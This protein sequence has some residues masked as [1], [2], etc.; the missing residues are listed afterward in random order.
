VRTSETL[1]PAG[2]NNLY[3][4]ATVS[5]VIRQVNKNS[6]EN[7]NYDKYIRITTTKEEDARAI[8][9]AYTE[10]NSEKYGICGTSCLDVPQEALAATGR[11]FKRFLLTNYLI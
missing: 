5:S 8:E 6:N 3:K 7:H 2:G 11:K 4:G 1:A 10:A 9:A